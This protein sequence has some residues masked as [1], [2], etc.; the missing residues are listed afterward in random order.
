MQRSA[1]Q[2][3]AA[4][5]LVSCSSE[6]SWS[7][8]WFLVLSLPSLRGG[9]HRGRS[10]TKLHR[11]AGGVLACSHR[12]T[13]RQ[14]PAHHARLLQLL[15]LVNVCRTPVPGQ[16]ATVLSPGTGSR[17]G[18]RVVNVL[19]ATSLK[20]TVLSAGYAGANRRRSR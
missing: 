7:V 15:G 9:R 16:G 4:M 19:T 14:K 17:A 11:R 6:S 5:G 3:G 10:V 2:S 20:D 8:R 13:S 12:A 1:V 18:A